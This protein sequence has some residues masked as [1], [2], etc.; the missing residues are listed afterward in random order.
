LT[1]SLSSARWG[2]VALGAATLALSGLLLVAYAVFLLSSAAGDPASVATAG[3]SGSLALAALF[4]GLG[5]IAFGSGRGR[6]PLFATRGPGPWLLAFVGLLVVGQG[7]LSL[8]PVAAALALAPVQFAAAACVAVSIS[9][10]VAWRTVPRTWI[11]ALSGFAAGGC[12]AATGA[13]LI[14]LAAFVILAIAV[15]AWLEVRGDAAALTAAL[16]KLA[17]SGGSGE[18]DPALWDL[19]LR[20]SVVIAGFALVAVIA[21]AIE[22]TLKLAMAAARHPASAA[23]A[24][25]WGVVVGAGFGLVEGMGMASMAAEGWAITMIVRA[26]DSIMHATLTGSS[27]LGWFELRHGAPR[28]RALLRI[29]AAYLG[30]MLWNTLVFGAA[31]AGLLVATGRGPSVLEPLAGAATLGVVLVFAAIFMGYRAVTRALE[32]PRPLPE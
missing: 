28:G 2:V 29:A 31:A 5:L 21:P 27:S 6:G 25:W 10:F 15:Y 1:K 4:M 24:W 8:P 7:A 20:P 26:I 9:G 11:D 14:E 13:L 22:E 23:D 16:E 12:L 19:L 3:A 17:A 18:I 32:Q 30:H